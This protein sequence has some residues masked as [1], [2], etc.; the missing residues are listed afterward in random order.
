MRKPRK[1]A[2]T[3]QH[4]DTHD[5]QEYINQL[6]QALLDDKVEKTLDLI[7]DLDPS[8][9]ALILNALPDRDREQMWSSL[10]ATQRGAC[11]PYL[12]EDSRNRF[13]VHMDAS[14]IAASVGDLASDD[15]AEILQGLPERRQR[16]ILRVMNPKD[17]ERI[18][19]ILSYSVEQAGSL[20]NTEFIKVSADSSLRTV[21]RRLHRLERLP[22]GTDNLIAVDKRGKY[23]GVLPLHRILT[24]KSDQIVRNCL[25]SRAQAIPPEMSVD[26]L[27]RLF[28]EKDLVSAPVVGEDGVPLGRITIDDVVDVIEQQTS[29]KMLMQAGLTKEESTFSPV[30]VSMWTRLPW[31]GINL[32]TAFLASFVI[33]LFEQSISQVVAL[34]I[35]M[36]VVASMGGIAGSQTLTITTRGLALGQVGKANVGS[37]ISKEVSISALNGLVWMLTVT[38]IVYLWFDNLWLGMVFGISIFANLVIAALSGVTIPLALQRLGVDPAI[39]GGVILTTVT[40]IVGFITFLGLGTVLLIYV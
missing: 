34:A 17:R 5:L 12:E 31:L 13:M 8:S 6:R 14:Q 35:L 7:I 40:D 1:Y 25:E 27:A 24:S 19:T 18:G 9:L 2:L 10:S 39:A 33:G 23:V 3:T 4:I 11:L 38:G 22:E 28:S 37:L 26:L 15:A 29:T 20:M 36:P 16:R 30:W 32:A 21:S